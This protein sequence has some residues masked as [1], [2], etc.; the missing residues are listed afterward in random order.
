[1]KTFFLKFCVVILTFTLVNCEN[2]NKD[3]KEIAKS[4]ILDHYNFSL[5]SSQ[6]LNFQID[7]LSSTIDY[8]SID[9]DEALNNPKLIQKWEEFKKLHADNLKGLSINDLSYRMEIFD[10]VTIKYKWKADAT[11]KNPKVLLNNKEL[12]LNDTEFKHFKVPVDGRIN[13][14]LNFSGGLGS[15]SFKITDVIFKDGSKGVV[16]TEPKINST[17]EEKDS[18]FFIIKVEIK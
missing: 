14:Y 12:D 11:V 10:D 5:A 15:Y 4:T 7:S 1:M 6:H 18:D 9:V 8:N 17:V 3:S 13:A 2:S 16:K